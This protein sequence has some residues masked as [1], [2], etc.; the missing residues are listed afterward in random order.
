MRGL[1]QLLRAAADVGF[2]GQPVA[3]ICV[4][5]GAGGGPA[6]RALSS[7]LAGPQP[8]APR[9]QHQQQQQAGYASWRG[10]VPVHDGSDAES[11]SDDVGIDASR[12]QRREN[13]IRDL[14][15]TIGSAGDMRFVEG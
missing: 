11:D 14:V 9:V 2:C 8:L 6:L 5:G 4:A 12:R 3:E 15:H 1:R 7:L 10:K 13:R